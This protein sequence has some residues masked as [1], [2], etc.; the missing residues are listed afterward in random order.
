MKIYLVFAES[1]IGLVGLLW[2]IKF[3]FDRIEKRF[4]PPSK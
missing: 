3:A 1:A 2:L 4:S